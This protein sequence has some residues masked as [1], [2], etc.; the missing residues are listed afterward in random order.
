MDLLGVQDGDLFN[1]EGK[2]R[3]SVQDKIANRFR[4]MNNMPTSCSSNKRSCNPTSSCSLNGHLVVLLTSEHVV[5]GVLLAR[6]NFTT[7]LILVAEPRENTPN[8]FLAE[9]LGGW[10]F[11]F[12]QLG[13]YAQFAPVKILTTPRSQPWQLFWHT[14]LVGPHVFFGIGHR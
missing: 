14:E 6:P 7:M 4:I 1:L 9:R 11:H 8:I 3:R 12:S 2:L 5:I 10:H 13:H